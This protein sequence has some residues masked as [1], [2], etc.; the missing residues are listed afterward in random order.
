VPD[1]ERFRLTLFV[2]GVVAVHA[3]CL[4]ALLPVL[5]TLPGPDNSEPKHVVVDVDVL[6]G[7]APPATGASDVTFALPE[8]PQDAALGDPIAARADA[9]DAEPSPAPTALPLELTGPKPANDAAVLPG[10]DAVANIGPESSP[11]LM[12]EG[13]LEGATPADAPKADASPAEDQDVTPKVELPSKKPA[14]KKRTTVTAKPAKPLVH[15]QAKAEATANSSE[16][17]GFGSFFGVPQS[18]PATKS[19]PPHATSG[20]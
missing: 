12:P 2:L 17:G 13:T 8:L 4:A 1:Q 16:A 7:S 9:S 5:I 18:Q 15:R 10:P 14:A 3:L 11:T 19:K 6:S 20:R